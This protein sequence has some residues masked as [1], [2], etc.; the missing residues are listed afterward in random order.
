MDHKT[1]ADER[2]ELEERIRSVE[3]S[4][5]PKRVEDI[6]GSSLQ[7]NGHMDALREKARLLSLYLLVK[8]ICEAKFKRQA[9]NV[10]FKRHWM[11]VQAEN[12]SVQ[13]R[14]IDSIHRWLNDCS[15]KCKTS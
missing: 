13:C 3:M 1:T 2:A 9:E 12:N 8:N 14:V 11:D 4:I 7:H 15:Y 6:I 5:A 10:K